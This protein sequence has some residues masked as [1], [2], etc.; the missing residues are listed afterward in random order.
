[1]YQIQAHRYLQWTCYL[2]LSKRADPE[3]VLLPYEIALTCSTDEG[4]HVVLDI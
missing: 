4:I 3:I 1:M 2:S